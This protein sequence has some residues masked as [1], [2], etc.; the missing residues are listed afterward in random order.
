MSAQPPPDEDVESAIAGLERRLRALQAELDAERGGVPAPPPTPPHVAPAPTPPPRATPGGARVET[1]RAAASRW[2]PPRP[3]TGRRE[4]DPP[5]AVPPA[6]APPAAPP[7]P[8]GGDPFVDALERFGADLRRLTGELNSAWEQL[9][10]DVSGGG[11]AER[12]EP[13]F[14]GEVALEV[15]AQLGTLAAIDA[16]LAAITGVRGVALR[17]YAGRR[18]VLDVALDG[19]V[20]LVRELRGTLGRPF[21]VT[22]TGPGL[23]AIDLGETG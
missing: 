23:L 15:E 11:A 19:D 7:A 14:R 21:R 1:A 20:A 3:E 5:P 13:V 22:A 10:A 6:A 16:A 2:A 17:T 9:V 8:S 4:T 18:A 12:F